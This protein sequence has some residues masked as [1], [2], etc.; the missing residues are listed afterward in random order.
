MNMNIPLSGMAN[1]AHRQGVSANN[2]ANINTPG[3]RARSVVSA[4]ADGGGVRVSEVR[5]DPSPGPVDVLSLSGES[6]SN[7]DLA[8]E[9]VSNVLFAAAYKA[10]AAV[11]RTENDMLGTLLNVQ[12]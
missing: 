5:E 9:S 8:T 3:Y 7:V 12:R 1:A 4:E 2:V 11:V 6:G 10:N